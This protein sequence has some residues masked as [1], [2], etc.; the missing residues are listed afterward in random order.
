MSMA[1]SRVERTQEPKWVRFRTALTRYVASTSALR[2]FFETIEPLVASTESQRLESATKAVSKSMFS[3]LRDANSEELEAAMSELQ[4]RADGSLTATRTP[5]KSPIVRQLMTMLARARG[6][7]HLQHSETLRRSILVSLVTNFEVLISD[8]VHA[9]YELHPGAIG[10]NESMS[11]S[12]LRAFES[13]DDAVASIV[14][15]KVENLLRGSVESW[16]DFL[17][18]QAKVNFVSTFPNR[19]RFYECFKRRNLLVHSAGQVNSVYLSIVS[20]QSSRRR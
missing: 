7:R 12:D 16:I 5:P 17:E 4:E 9:H 20:G 6:P 11:L 2:E 10:G 15:G 19:A 18:R 1:Q 13:I 8:I 14:S 3:I